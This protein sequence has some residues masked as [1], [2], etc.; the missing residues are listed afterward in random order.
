MMATATKD[1]A[2][3]T[4]APAA[5]PSAPD[6]A[7]PEAP[8]T[9]DQSNVTTVAKASDRLM[10]LHGIT[11]TRVGMTGL[12]ARL[13]MAAYLETVQGI[14]QIREVSRFWLGDLLNAGE[15]R[16]GEKYAQAL[17]VTGLDYG[18]LR[19]ITSLSSRFP[20]ER[21]RPELTWT[22]H[23]AVAALDPETADELL[24]K[25]IDE[26]LSVPALRALVKDYKA[27]RNSRQRE[28]GTAPAAAQSAPIGSYPSEV[29]DAGPDAEWGCNV[30][31]AGFDEMAWHC[32]ECNRHWRPDQV[33][34]PACT[35]AEQPT[36]STNGAAQTGLVISPSDMVEEAPSALGVLDIVGR[37]SAAASTIPAEDVY[38]EAIAADYPVPMAETLAALMAADAYLQ[39]IIEQL[40]EAGTVPTPPD[41]PQTLSGEAESLP[42]A[43]DGEEGEDDTPSPVVTQ[44]AASRRA[45][46]APSIRPAPKPSSG[47]RRATPKASEAQ[48]TDET[49]F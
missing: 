40:S 46:K 47:K 39:A 4:E 19:N 34:C 36:G 30:C 48:E 7:K 11:F 23:N 32:L 1:K 12:P 17:D 31:K 24:Q 9:D 49:D 16:Y 2:K 27:P 3:A 14:S 8:A 18:S 33:V 43:E 38:V 37:L 45:T 15:Q 44:Q 42:D 26:G 25:S 29:P 22:H 21:R 6:E 10:Q 35:G 41:A 20:I 13:S 28:N 5:V